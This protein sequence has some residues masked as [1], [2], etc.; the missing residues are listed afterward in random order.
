MIAMASKSVLVIF[1][2]LVFFSG[3]S[4]VFPS[5]RSVAVPPGFVACVLGSHA[6]LLVLVSTF[7]RLSL[8]VPD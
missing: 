7:S 3:F 8:V 5:V 6:V 1:L 2:Y 4:T